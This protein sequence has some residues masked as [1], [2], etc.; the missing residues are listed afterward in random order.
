[1]ISK[2]G[3][4][5]S[6]IFFCKF[7]SLISSEGRSNE[8]STKSWKSKEVLYVYYLINKKKQFVLKIQFWMKLPA[9][10]LIIM[11]FLYTTCGC[12]FCN[13]TFLNSV[14]LGFKLFQ[15]LNFLNKR[16]NYQFY[17]ES[18]FE[19]FLEKN[20]LKRNKIV[21]V[22]FRY[23]IVYCQPPLKVKEYLLNILNQDSDDSIR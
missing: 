20:L 15:I 11:I 12:G 14:F 21:S 7:C 19:I 17:H 4:K 6:L 2:T 13:L 1:M 8:N 3:G 18:I 9:N 5:S 16:T 22:N 10:Y 23:Y